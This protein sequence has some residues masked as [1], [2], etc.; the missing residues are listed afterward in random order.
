MSMRVGSLALLGVAA[1][2]SP[3]AFE[4]GP[5]VPLPATATT[6][7]AIPTGAA[8]SPASSKVGPFFKTEDSDAWVSH[9]F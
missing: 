9:S 1:C 7:S 8:S 6:V 2:H 3:P 5:D 4:Q